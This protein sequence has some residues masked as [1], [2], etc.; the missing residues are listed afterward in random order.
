MT[1]FLD[2]AAQHGLAVLITVGVLLAIGAFFD[3][4]HHV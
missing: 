3:A 4:I 2:L 1:T